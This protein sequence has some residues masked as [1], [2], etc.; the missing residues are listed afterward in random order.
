MKPFITMAMTVPTNVPMHISLIVEIRF[1][2]GRG[3][4]SV[5]AFL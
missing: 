4:D 5:V 1:D 3:S 2:L